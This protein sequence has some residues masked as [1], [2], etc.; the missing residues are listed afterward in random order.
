[1]RSQYSIAECTAISRGLS[2]RDP[3][4]HSVYPKDTGWL[5][6]TRTGGVAT[7][8]PRTAPT[9]GDMPA[10]PRW[11]RWPCRAAQPAEFALLL[12]FVHA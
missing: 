4:G 3:N 2:C 8:M 11:G 10:C 9:F 12:P 5:V 6:S 7:A 1:M